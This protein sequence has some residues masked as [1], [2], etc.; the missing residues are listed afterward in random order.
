VRRRAR[1]DAAAQRNLHFIIIII[2][3]QER[4]GAISGAVRRILQRRRANNLF[5]I[6][7]G[8]TAM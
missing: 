6:H 3:V 4:A 7:F 5:L 1:V 8:A 2:G